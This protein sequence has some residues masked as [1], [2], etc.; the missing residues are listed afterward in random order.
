MHGATARLLFS[1]YV[2]FLPSAAR[3]GVARLFALGRAARWPAAPL[4]AP[5]ASEAHAAMLRSLVFLVVFYVNTALFLVLGSW[6]LLAP[7]SWAMEGLRLHGLASLWWLK[8]ICGTRYEVRGREKL[9]KGACLVASKHQSA[10]DTFALIP[11]FRDPAMVMK[12][13]LG[14]IP[15]YGWFCHKFQ[16]IFVSRDR[17]PSA[18][19]SLIRDARQRAG[20]G[21]RDRHLPRGHAAAA[22][23]A[24]RLQAGLHRA[25]RGPGPAL[26]SAGAQL[27]PVLAA[28]Q[29]RALPR[30]HRHRGARSHPA[31]PAARARPAP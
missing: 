5:R 31:G 22:G 30:H 20:P 19:K 29:H 28:P 7:R 12:A 25:L 13:E 17:G 26:L 3:F 18:L 10:W 4:C 21:P 9:P 1:E 24:A 14:W 8:V 2:K 6:L 23:R 11:V 27:R 15:L 16:H